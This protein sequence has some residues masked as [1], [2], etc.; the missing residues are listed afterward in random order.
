MSATAASSAAAT[1]TAPATPQVVT[2]PP[3]E[4]TIAD[5]V[6][7]FG[8]FRR[9]LLA[10]LAGEQAL[11]GWRPAAGDLG[12]QVLEWWAYLGDVLTFYNERIANESYL[13]TA[14]SPQRL[15][16]LVAL[17]GYRPKPGIGA[18]G[19]VALL[20]G[21]AHPNE[22]LSV[23]DGMALSS[24]ATPGVPAQRFEVQGDWT[25]P[26]PSDVAVAL[27]PDNDLALNA[28]GGPASV[29]LAGRVT[30]VAP[31]DE[32]LLVA[33]GWSASSDS[34]WA[35]V[36][37]AGVAASVDPGTGTQNTQVTFSSSARFGP[38][39]VVDWL[40][41]F[42][43]AEHLA[44]LELVR[45]TRTLSDL[46]AGRERS[47]PHESIRPE[48]RRSAPIDIFWSPGPSAPVPSTAPQAPSYQLLRPSQ[49]TSLFNQ[50]NP[51]GAVI[52][53]STAPLTAHL[54]AAVRSITPGEL[55][56]FDGA[57]SGVGLTSVAST[58]EVMWVMPYPAGAPAATTTPTPSPTPAP[59]IVVAHTALGLTTP[60][61]SVLSAFPD[62]TAVTL[63]YGFKPVGTVIGTP[64]AS[65]S[66][67]PATVQVPAGWSPANGSQTAIL[68]DST[69]Y[70]LQ[71]AVTSA[72]D[73]EAQLAPSGATASEPPTPLYVPLRLLLD[74]VP[75]TRGTTVASETLGSGN[76]A[77]AGQSFSLQRSPLTYLFN[78]T[79]ISSTLEVYVGG[80]AW[81]EVP[82]LF[83]QDPAA[84]VYT[85]M[86]APDG[87]AT[88]T[89]GD[90]VNGARL[91]TGTG[92][93]VA[94]YRYG[95]GAASPPAGRLTTITRPQ[96]NLAAVANPIAVF[97]GLDAQTA[98]DVRS[99]A[100]AS[101][102][103][104]GPPISGTDYAVIAGQAPGVTRVGTVWS[105]DGTAQRTTVTVYVGGGPGA[106]ASALDALAG[107]GDPNR[108][109]TI[110]AAT[111][112]PLDVSC[113]LQ[114]QA[115]R[116][117]GDVQAAAVAAL[118]DPVAGPLSPAALGIGQPLYRSA[119]DAALSVDGVS[120]VTGLT[121]S[122][123]SALL[124]QVLSPGTGA[125]F[126][127]GNVAGI[128]AV[129]SG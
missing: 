118:S 105:F 50:A 15:A 74:L 81:T 51:P 117:A 71:V 29:L 61:T 28:A 126:T 42:G 129:A 23:P 99:D 1:S 82:S 17:I 2:N 59:S 58:S 123:G 25:F 13:R 110:V 21:A 67:L 27:A 89:F 73:G 22:P 88:V 54:S 111:A 87:S 80:I 78:G 95:S 60:D 68:Q 6:G 76:S 52:D 103:T 37:V 66:Q 94:S 45:S 77:V 53:T 108:P 16:E 98:D 5:R 11:A 56:L 9:A 10:P 100:P 104:F 115:G 26:G 109:V 106:V 75:V 4:A 102:A 8:A 97:G 85:V 122:T 127:L 30:T 57:A 79:G 124:G 65:L 128:Q 32:L 90:G 24:T 48:L 93:V 33:R 64:V 47:Q 3:G 46:I 112:V 86:L 101:V 72:G 62:P 91:P 31:G 38:P 34:D 84:T 107:A 55:V 96:P 113:T 36:Q 114:V 14:R 40:H 63:R 12:L 39:P 19:Q 92:N 69:G 49:T 35:W 41:L 83:D 119:I 121:V 7:D 18:T 43:E 120:S 44:G 70:G 20:R 116:I 125:Y